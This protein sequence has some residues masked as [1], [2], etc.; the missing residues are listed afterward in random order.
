MKGE[1]NIGAR[2]RVRLLRL[3]KERGDDFQLV[4]L[5]FVHERL[6]FRLSSSIHAG[7][8]VL[9]G[10]ALFTV[11]TGHPH[12]ATRDLDLLGFGD[13]T[14]AHLRTVFAEIATTKTA[15]DGVTFD[16]ATIETEP[17][18]AEEE[19]GGVRVHLE[20]RVATARI[21]LQVDIGFGDAITPEASI[22]EF[23][24]LLDFP[25]PRLRAYPRET[26]VAEKVEALVKLGLANSRMKDFYDLAVLAR[27]F[28][29]DGAQLA[30]A[31]RATFERRGTALPE[32]TP[33][34]LT[35]DFA[36]APG[37]TAQWSGFKRK[38]AVA[39]AGGLEEAVAEVARFVAEPL[40]AA[41]AAS[42]WDG[43]WPAG[44]PWSG[45]SSSHR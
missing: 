31:L 14:E 19:Y 3:A 24:A 32:D 13:A 41:R 28:P 37:K 6:L 2:A 26:V 9:K 43:N 30:S 11:W 33:V 4:L 1:P 45:T 38:G 17:I 44:G 10:A 35:A 12:R 7:S 27:L 39:D 16:P 34:A 40:A 42:R 23:P 20:A 22:V 25:A 29:F 18:R 15:D 36:N 8:F 5:R 21:R